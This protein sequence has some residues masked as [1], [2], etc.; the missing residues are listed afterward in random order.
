MDYR[1]AD[2]QKTESLHFIFLGDILNETVIPHIRFPSNELAAYQFL[3]PAA[4]L[5][6]LD[7]HLQRRITAALLAWKEERTIYLED[8][9]AIPQC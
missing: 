6:L 4:A 1:P 5:P 3:P 7:R 9:H 2:K 8:G